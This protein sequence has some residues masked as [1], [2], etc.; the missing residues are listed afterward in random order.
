MKK[1]I[2]LN[3]FVLCCSIVYLAIIISY[4]FITN[5]LLPFWF[6]LAIF[7]IGNYLFLKAYFFNLD[8]SFWLA[9]VLILMGSI[10]FANFLMDYSIQNVECLYILTLAIASCFTG[11]FYKK[12]LH[13]YFSFILLLEDF[14]ILLYINNIISLIA[15]III[16]V[17][18][19]F[20]I[21]GGI[22]VFKRDK[23]L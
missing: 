9:I 22:Y 20:V 14:L 18:T 21:M 16:N 6:S 2:I 5:S 12:K 15:F 7:L 23:R 10:G 1:T 17:L 3:Y 19:I 11:L 13:Y 8:S 4:F